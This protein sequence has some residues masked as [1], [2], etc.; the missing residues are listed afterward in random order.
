V[1]EV[2]V[3]VWTPPG[4]EWPRCHRGQRDPA[5]TPELLLAGCVRRRLPVAMASEEAPSC[6]NGSLQ[7]T[8]PVGASV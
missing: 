5:P 3:P 2:A 7:A 4:G 1:G 6:D 8:F